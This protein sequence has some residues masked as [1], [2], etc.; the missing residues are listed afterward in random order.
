MK[1]KIKTLENDLNKKNKEIQEYIS[2]INEEKDIITSTKLGEK[3]MTVNFV[4][5]GNNDIGHYSVPCKK[6]RFIY[7]IRGKII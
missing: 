6:N 3:I 1:N 5:M 2:H 4:S 7:K